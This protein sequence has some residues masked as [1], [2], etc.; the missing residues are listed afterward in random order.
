MAGS[1]VSVSGT[2]V[3]IEVCTRGDLTAVEVRE[4]VERATRDLQRRGEEGSD[5]L[6][7]LVQELLECRAARICPAL[8]VAWSLTPTEVLTCAVRAVR[9]A[10]AAAPSPAAPRFTPETC[11]DAGVAWSDAASVTAYASQVCSEL[12]ARLAATVPDQSVASESDTPAPLGSSPVGHACEGFLV[13]HAQPITACAFSPDGRSILSAGSEG[14]LIVWD[15]RTRSRRAVFAGGERTSACCFSP[16]GEVIAWAAGDAVRLLDV[17]RGSE[18]ATLKGHGNVVSDCAFFPDGA[19]LVSA[20]WDKTVRIWD[21]ATREQV[22]LLAGHGSR[23][24]ACA[25]SPDGT[26]VASASWGGA[27]RLW[28]AATG[29]AVLTLT[30]HSDWVNDCA[31]SS[32]GE[33]LLSA[34]S[35][36]TLKAWRVDTGDVLAT[37]SG[38]EGGVYACALSP[39][40]TMAASAGWDG[41]LRLWDVARGSE[42]VSFRG[43]TEPLCACAFS[44]DGSAVVSAGSDCAVRVWVTQ[45]TGVEEGAVAP[46]APP[47]WYDEPASG[48]LRYW[49]GAQWTSWV[50]DGSGQVHE[51]RGG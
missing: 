27:L 38:H 29:E 4:R 5:A 7:R 15:T 49:D 35:D 3:I 23:V 39:E 22:L 16:D 8:Q 47:G 42:R 21:L 40:G 18:R 1:L 6:A 28:N 37:L 46:P 36:G 34:S 13:G 33:T 30:G 17:G 25:V 11:T 32:D 41:T 48:A 10:E 31:F 14:T 43:H 44:P 45:A 50:C 26:T 12:E 2:D 19:M 9:D 51:S 20:S 24:S